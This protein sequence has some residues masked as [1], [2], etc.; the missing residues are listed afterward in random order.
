MRK[1]AQIGFPV[2]VEVAG[3]ESGDARGVRG[4]AVH[5]QRGACGEPAG[6]VPGQDRDL[7]RS[8]PE[9][10]RR[11][12]GDG[13]VEVAVSVEVSPRRLEE[14]PRPRRGDRFRLASERPRLHGVRPDHHE[15]R[16]PVARELAR[17]EGLR[18]DRPD[19][20]DLG[21]DGKIL[22]PRGSVNEERRE[23][24]ERDPL[25]NLFHGR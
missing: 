22:S 2:T 6:A 13:E 1:D 4:S 15:E 3:G 17:G 24:S 5:V 16:L 12:D 11:G 7:A 25:R 20:R 21:Q 19:R 14:M 8:A 9:H 10:A 23:G 18:E